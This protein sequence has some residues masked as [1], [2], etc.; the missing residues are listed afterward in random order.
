MFLTREMVASGP[1][2]GLMSRPNA[3]GLRLLS[4]S[5]ARPKWAAAR[6]A[7]AAVRN[8]L[9]FIACRS[10]GG[11]DSIAGYQVGVLVVVMLLNPPPRRQVRQEFSRRT[12]LTSGH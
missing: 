8:S 6:V 9:R 2:A 5:A 4:A 7:P 10:P 12:H 1:S 11:N 3:I